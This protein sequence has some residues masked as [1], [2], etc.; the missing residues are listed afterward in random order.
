MKNISILISRKK[1][2]RFDEIFRQIVSKILYIDFTKKRK[3]QRFDEIF[4]QIVSTHCIL[5]SN[6]FRIISSGLGHCI[7]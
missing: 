2:Q 7:Q 3:I 1:N 5:F 4:R 6:G